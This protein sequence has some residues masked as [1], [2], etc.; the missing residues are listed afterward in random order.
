M[1][2][3]HIICRTINGIRYRCKDIG[4]DDFDRA[5]YNRYIGEHNLFL[6]GYLAVEEAVKR[7]PANQPLASWIPRG[8]LLQMGRKEWQHVLASR[9]S[10]GDREDELEA[11]LSEVVGQKE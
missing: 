7:T 8:E 11:F 2:Q 6:A 10:G 4:C 9:Q 3:E 5:E 1:S